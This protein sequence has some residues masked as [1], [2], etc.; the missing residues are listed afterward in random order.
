MAAIQALVNQRTG[1]RQGN[2]NVAYYSLAAG[3]YGPDGNPACD[4][5]LGNQIDGSC[6]F[7]DITEGDIDL[8]CS[9]STDCYAPSGTNGVLSTSDTTFQPAYEA[10]PGWDFATGIGTVNAYNLVVA[11]GGPITT[12]TTTLPCMTARCL[13]GGVLDGPACRAEAIP[14]SVT[15]KLNRAV[16]LL[17]T[18]SSSTANKAK[19]LR[20]HAKRLLKLATQAVGKSAKGKKPKINDDCATSIQRV[21]DAVRSGIGV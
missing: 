16:A 12:T 21:I 5:S 19:R 20:K 13:F 4:S 17:D 1:E 8:S 2:P 11:L 14:G 6:V 3:Q 15:N 10:R 18:S 9:G 7:H